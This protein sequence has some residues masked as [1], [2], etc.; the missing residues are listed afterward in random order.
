MIEKYYS[1]AGWGAMFVVGDERRGRS[2]PGLAAAAAPHRAQSHHTGRCTHYTVLLI[3][4]RRR[5]G[6]AL[7]HCSSC[8]EPAAERSCPVCSHLQHPAQVGA[9][10]TQLRI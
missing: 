8:P 3:T 2:G 7:Q 9:S 5:V 1:S 6:A 4:K 10:Q